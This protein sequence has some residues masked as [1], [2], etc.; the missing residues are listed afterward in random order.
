MKLS[1]L[2]CTLPEPYS[3][4]MLRRLMRIVEPQTNKFPGSVEIRIH[5]AGRSM[6]TGTKRNHLIHDSEGDYFSFI[7][8]DDIVPPYYVSEMLTA[9]EQGPDVITFKGYMTTNESNRR[10]FTIRKGSDYAE[11]NGHYYRWPNHLCAFRRSAVAHIKFPPIWHQEDYQWS[12]KVRDLGAI[13]TEVHIDKDMYVYDFR[14]NK[15]GT[16]IKRI[17]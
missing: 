2:I 1:I 5:D 11:R 8:C 3:I 14:N 13:K 9:I 6:P 15:P 7:D 12:K 10:D 4:S 16:P 17:R